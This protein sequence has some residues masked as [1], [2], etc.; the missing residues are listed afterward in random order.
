MSWLV[1]HLVGDFME[2]PTVTALVSSSIPIQSVTHPGVSIC[3]MNKFSKQ[4]AYKFAE[5]LNAKYYNNKKNISAILND[6]KLLGSLYDFRRIHRAY[7]EFQSILELDY[8]NLADGYDPAKHIEQLTTPCSE[9]LRKC[10]WSGG[11]RNCNELFFTRT[12]YEGPCC[13]F[14]YMKPGLIGLVII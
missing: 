4:R 1:V 9:M 5:Y 11:E 12:T 8:D 3:N 13:V 10:Y 2:S 14:N 6:I 7:R